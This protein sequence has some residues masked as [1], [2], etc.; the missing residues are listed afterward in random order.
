M[1][2]GLALRMALPFAL[3]LGIAEVV[4]NWGDWGFWPFWVVDYIAVALL[5]WAW[6]AAGSRQAGGTPL[7]AGAWGFTCAMFYM[8]F[9]AHLESLEVPER[10]PIDQRPLTV[11]I[12]ILFGVTVLGFASSLVAAKGER[13]PSPGE[14]GH[15]RGTGAVGQADAA[16][17]ASGRRPA[18]VSRRG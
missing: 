11:I 3:F 12:G 13:L 16:D 1:I 14:A 8:A 15:P 2:R 18:Q 17:G 7:L 4:R 5:I 9:F 10:G 6:W